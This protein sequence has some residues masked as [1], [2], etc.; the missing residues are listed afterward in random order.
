MR[1]VIGAI[2]LAAACGL[3]PVR[4]G[5][6]SLSAER[7]GV[8]APAASASSAAHDRTRSPL[9]VTLASAV[10]PGAGQALLG[11]RR[12]FFYGAAEVAGWAVYTVQLR[13]GDGQRTTYRDLSR[14]VARAQ[15]VPNGPPGNWDYY[16]RME[17]FAVSGAYDAIAG[18]GID[19]ELDVTTYN[20]SMW[21]LARQTY[22]RDPAVSPSLASPEYQQALSFYERRAVP[23]ELRW[24]WTASPDGF[25]QYRH[26]I[27]A[28]N[29]AFKRAQQTIGLVIANHILSVV[30]AYVSVRL[31][32]EPNGRTTLAAGIP[33]GS[34]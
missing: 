14:S 2:A 11:S 15:F 1:H 17:K 6:Q 32:R 21:L 20:G 3:A 33:F 7:A 25:Q 19:P 13:D 5:A 29:A 8:A 27:A 23:P 24:S 12:A 9:V 34:R 30:D 4:V 28:S 26:S 18:G 31:R 22:W 16:E 10:I